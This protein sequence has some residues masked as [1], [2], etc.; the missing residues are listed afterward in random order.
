MK[1]MKKPTKQ[2]LYNIIYQQLD[3]IKELRQELRQATAANTEAGLLKTGAF[4]FIKREN[5]ALLQRLIKVEQRLKLLDPTSELFQ[6]LNGP[7]LAGENFDN[8]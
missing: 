8:I 4:K 5:T 6:Q 2:E 1:V 3:T 7:P